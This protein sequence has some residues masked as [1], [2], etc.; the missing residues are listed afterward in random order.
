[1]RVSVK[2]L[3]RYAAIQNKDPKLAAEVEAGTKKM[4]DAEKELRP[5]KPEPVAVDKKPTPAVESKPEKDFAYY[6]EQWFDALGLAALQID[7]AM[8]IQAEYRKR[9]EKL[10]KQEQE[11]EGQ[12]MR[13]MGTIDLHS[14]LDTID[15]AWSAGRDLYDE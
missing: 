15:K 1:M 5:A 7:G 13:D 12:L 6:R 11:S 14:V 10:S 9:F 3:D 4:V 8:A 2:Q